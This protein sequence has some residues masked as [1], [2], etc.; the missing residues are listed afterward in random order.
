MAA[1]QNNEKFLFTFFHSSVQ[2][3]GELIL[4]DTMQKLLLPR[5]HSKSALNHN[6]SQC[7]FLLLSC[8]CQSKIHQRITFYYGSF[9]FISK[10]TCAEYKKAALIL[11]LSLVWTELVLVFLEE[12]NRNS[13]SFLHEK[14]TVDNCVF[15]I[16][17]TLD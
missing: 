5:K 9:Y 14:T 17:D 1:F 3:I 2:K 10:K 16:S 11:K 12:F 15:I 7:V 13:K 8:S 4:M 6:F